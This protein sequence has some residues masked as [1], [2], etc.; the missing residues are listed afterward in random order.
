MDFYEIK[1]RALKSGT[2][3][4]RPAWRVLRFKDL[5][6]RGKS[7]YAVYNPETH[8]WSTEEYDLMRIVDSD[9]ARRF[10]EAS[11]RVD[12]SVWARYLGDYDS[13]TYSDYKAWMSKLPDVYHPLD[14]G[15][16]FA[17]Q[18]PRREDYATRTLTYS[19]SDDPCPAYE[20]LMS[21]LYDPDEREKLEWGIGAVFTGD[22]KWIQKF[23]VLYGSAG[24]GKSTVLNLISRLLDDHIG[25]FD[26]AALGRPSDQ[27]ALEPFKSNPR[28]AIQHDGNLARIA[29]NS[30]LNSL[31]SHETMVMNE[32]G[33]SLYSFTSEAMLFVGTNLP[34]RITDSKSGLTRRL[35]DVEPSGRKL[36]IHRYNDI[37]DRIEEERGSIVKHC[38]D[39][40]KSKGSSYYDDYK[41]IGMMSK[42]NPI[43]NFLDFYQDELNDE[44]GISLKRIYEMYKEY[45]QSYS[46]GYVYPMFRFK[47]EIRD[48]FE[49]FHDRIMINGVSRRKVYKGLLKSKFSQGEKQESPIPDWTDMSKRDSYLDELYKD[50]PAQYANEN[51][52][53]AYR[54]DDVTT[55]LKDLDTRKEHYVLVPE[56]DI[57]IDIDLDKDRTRCHEE[58]RK[59]IPSYAELS[60][61]GGGV[62]I[63]Y[64]YP[65]DPSELSRMVAP[66]VECKVYSGKSALRRRLT[67]CTDHQGLTEV[68]VGYL[69]VK[70]QSVIKQEVMQSEKSIR[71]LISRNLRKEIHPGTKPSIDFIKKIL[72]DAYESGMPYDVSDIRQKVLTFAMKS[73][74][75]ADYCIKLVQEMHFSSEHDHEEEFEEPTDDDTPII[76]DVEVFPNLF[77]VN[78]KVRGSDEIQRMI[79]PTPNEISDI[80]EKKLV[81]FNNRR[82]DNHIL[83]G[84]ML[85]Y[86]NEQ[87]YHLSR[88]IISNL[89][90]EGFK[91]AYNLSYTDIY[92]FA[93][94]K[95]SL[96]R[97]EIELGIHHKELGLPWDEPVPEDRW[98]EVAAYCDNDVIA[99]EKVWDHLEADWEA[100][101]I[102]AS[103]AG[104][105]V[106]SSTNNLTTRIIFQGQRNTQQY[107]RYTDLSEMF[108][109]YKYEY[110]KSTYRG[111]EV[112]EGGYVYAEPGY[113]ENV[114]LLDIASMHPT[115][116]ENLQLFGPYTKRYSELK[117]A[118]ILIKH[119]ELDE[120]RKILNGALAPYLDDESNLDALAYA[121]KI[122]L[123]STYG[124][125]AA[126]FDNPLRDP[127]NVD[128]IVAKRGALFMVDLKHFV[129]EK[130]YTVT[131]IKT[132]SIKIP[133]S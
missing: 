68:E 44:E 116:I 115:S 42:T 51:G 23:F 18:T 99:T 105:P 112:G 32:K 34:V 73:T 83:Y 87:L 128:N 120:A 38:V 108:P 72:D 75:Q 95:Q 15:I 133:G 58:A 11:E 8:F 103:I 94:K 12:G 62:H 49:E 56:R 54:W 111:E 4:V 89:I 90:K 119:K 1:E 78:W 50:R 127:R 5:M 117:R 71:K 60:R 46:D 48:Y 13:K 29:D 31:I 130:G 61:S 57:V 131:H 84:R 27:F 33:K 126:K 52:L 91:E 123:N 3:E 14:G 26:A 110:G 25:Q 6:I 7:F 124:L 74:H 79:N 100:R 106:N 132:D 118:R 36:D 67:E 104:L 125:T 63:H 10:E 17:D 35:I 16:L 30:R 20:E 55:T 70:E 92:D 88:K 65:G 96:K 93:A 77:L 9:V 129:Q 19:L 40:Y 97:W 76:F 41:P 114:A 59:W 2:T 121:L 81:G 39:L 101:Q 43:F 85:G 98:E 64:R 28:V 47:D 53:P 122:A 37:M 22:S 113:H 21:T 86:S 107:L 66:G 45:S 24:S 82:Y 69:P 102:L 109:G 80:A